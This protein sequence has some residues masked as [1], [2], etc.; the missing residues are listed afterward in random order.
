MIGHNSWYVFRH[1]QAAAH[2]NSIFR[3]Y[4]R[5]LFLSVRS[6]PPEKQFSHLRITLMK[7]TSGY[8]DPLFDRLEQMAADDGVLTKQNIVLSLMNV[9][10]IQEYL[11]A[12]YS[13]DFSQSLKATIEQF[14]LEPLTSRGNFIQAGQPLKPLYSRF[15]EAGDFK[16]PD[17]TRSLEFHPLSKP[18]ME[19]AQNHYPHSTNLLV[20]L[21]CLQ[22]GVGQYFKDMLEASA[23]FEWIF[24][25]NDMQMVEEFLRDSTTNA[26]EFSFWHD[27]Y[28]VM[29]SSLKERVKTLDGQDVQAALGKAHRGSAFKSYARSGDDIEFRQCPFGKVIG[30]LFQTIFIENADGTLSVSANREPG[31]LI[32]FLADKGQAMIN[33]WPHLRKAPDG[34]DDPALLFGPEFV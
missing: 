9:R 33:L 8:F 1:E 19:A 18:E 32:L 5:T 28:P 15:A 20:A 27:L 6:H 7:A 26:N 3:Q 13:A 29:L 2:F 31:A 22:A 12:Y 10:H 17:G 34:T 11:A 23:H 21:A 4:L 25:G 24:D 30:H 16:L 14:R